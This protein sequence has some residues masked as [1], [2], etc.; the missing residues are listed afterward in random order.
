MVLKIRPYAPADASLWDRFVSGQSSAS[1]CHTSGWQRVV[2]RTWQHSQ[3]S[4]FAERDGQIVGVLPLF[5]VK[6]WF[7]SMLVSTPNG[8]YGGAVADDVAAHQALI[9]AA[10]K[11]ANEHQVDYLEL[12]DSESAPPPKGF[13]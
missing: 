8:V 2:E 5:L 4:L 13:L 7:G 3:H 6:S 12:R 1:I 10:Q 9:A 11:L